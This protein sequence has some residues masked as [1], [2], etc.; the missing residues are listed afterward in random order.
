MFFANLY[1]MNS[2]T[3]TFKCYNVT[4]LSWRLDIKSSTSCLCWKGE[5]GGLVRGLWR[6]NNLHAVGRWHLTSDREKLLQY[7][8]L[9]FPRYLKIVK[10][11]GECGEI[12]EGIGNCPEPEKVCFQGKGITSSTFIREPMGTATNS[13]KV[14]NLGFLLSQII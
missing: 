4:I 8:R 3:T 1:V 11:G 5:E 10:M 9:Y 7:L 2:R 14:L 6:R 13:Q 12:F